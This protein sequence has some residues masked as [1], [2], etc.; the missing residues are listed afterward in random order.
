MIV[1]PTV[2][3]KACVSGS[4]LHDVHFRLVRPND[5]RK[6]QR[7]HARLSFS[8]VQHRFHGGKRELSVPLAH[9]FTD[10][11][12]VDDAAIVA[13]TGTRGRIIGVARYCRLTPNSAEVAFVVEDAYQGKGIG[14]RLMRR[15]RELALA[16]GVTVFIAEVLADNVPMFH[17]LKQVGT[18]QTQFDHGVCEVHVDLTQRV[19]PAT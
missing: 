4:Q 9:T 16:N 11:D 19:G 13:T 15:L 12:G 18:A 10:V 6:L 3:R 7:F 17:L 8:S 5:W 1:H 2:R 14:G